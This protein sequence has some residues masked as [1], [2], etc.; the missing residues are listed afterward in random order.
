MAI[1]FVF[2][3]LA[4]LYESWAV[5]FAV[6]LGIPFAMLGAYGGLTLRGMANDIYAQIG[7]VMLI[8]LAAKN[9]ILIV[10]FAKLEYE[11]GK[12]LV[13]SAIEGARLRL[14]PILMTSFAFILGSLPLAI[15]TGAGAS[16]RRV[17][18]TAVVFGMSAAT[19]VGIF[20][21][22]VFY[23][24][25]Q[26]LSER[27]RGIADATTAPPPSPRATAIDGSRCAA[28]C[29]CAAALAAASRRWLLGRLQAGS[30]LP[31]ARYQVRR[32]LTASTALRTPPRWP[33][34]AGG[35]ST[36]MPRLQAADPR[37]TGQQS[38]RAHRRR[39][40]RPGAR[41]AGRD[42]PAAAA[43]DLRS[44]RRAAAA[45]PRSFEL[46]PGLPAISNVF[47]LEGSLSYEVDFWGKYRRATEAARAQLLQSD[48]ARQD[49]IAGAGGRR[50]DRVLHA[51]GTRRAGGYHRPHHRHAPEVRRTHQ[52]A[53]RARHRVGAGCRH[54]PGAAGDR[55]G[56]PARAAA[57]D[58]TGGRSAQRAARPQSGRRGCARSWRPPRP[59]PP[60]RRRPGACGRAS[61]PACWS[62]A[63]ICAKPSRT[64][65]PPTRRWAS[66]RRICFPPSRSPAPAAW[67][68]PHC[69]ACSP[70]PAQLWSFG[71]SLLQPLLDPQRSLYQL[72]LA[73][74]QKRA[75]VAAISEERADAPSRKCPMR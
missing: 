36:R 66:P 17:L 13:E 42:A 47:E 8:G 41:V 27:L 65:S 54:G 33:M 21:I 30:G 72:E 10:E 46:L 71:G 7:L 38:R 37:G 57:P 63:P 58:R 24:L 53:A 68:A 55:Q 59:S 35:R 12:P 70:A 20:L 11:R 56:Q 23:V 5:P 51:A 9:A 40:R 52:R 18:G 73:D 22:P 50:C 31:S 64:W 44:R 28:P 75:G 48:F 2:L 1:V 67:P 19:L 43:G 60:M 39:A 16:A 45:A 49:V 3:V 34:R 25:M 4:A 15:A 14:R 32:K 69:P 26:S 29:S 6:L 74:A 62:A 61:P